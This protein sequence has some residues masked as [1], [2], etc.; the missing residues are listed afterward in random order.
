MEESGLPVTGQNLTNSLNPSDFGK[1][2]F[3]LESHYPGGHYLKFSGFLGTMPIESLKG[4]KYIFT[5]FHGLGEN[6]YNP[7]KVFNSSNEF[8][9]IADVL[10]SEF[11]N[12]P[13]L[14]PL[15]DLAILVMRNEVDAKPFD[16]YL[17][18][19]KK[20][21]DVKTLSY[22][23]TGVGL[24]EDPKRLSPVGFSYGMDDPNVGYLE[25]ETVPGESGGVVVAETEPNQIKAIGTIIADFGRQFAL[26]H[27]FDWVKNLQDKLKNSLLNKLTISSIVTPE[28]KLPLKQFPKLDIP[29]KPV[30]WNSLNYV[31][32]AEFFVENLQDIEWRLFD[33]RGRNLGRLQYG[34]AQDINKARLFHKIVA[35]HNLLEEANLIDIEYPQI[36][37]EDISVLPKDIVENVQEYS[38]KF[39][40]VMSATENSFKPFITT[41]IGREGFCY[42]KSP[43]ER[44]DVMHANV[45]IDNKPITVQEWAQIERFFQALDKYGFLE[46]D[47]NYIFSNT[48]FNRKQ[49]GRL[50]MTITGFGKAGT[51]RYVPNIKELAMGL[52]ETGVKHI[53]LF[54]RIFY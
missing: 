14:G 1:S 46:G 10:F 44:N 27:G 25:G 53:S 39:N 30:A 40:T 6:P 51:Y 4:N 2:V 23:A 17:G 48:A 12:E 47:K 5:V 7:I 19:L 34:T 33:N 45:Q 15:R 16:L 13:S 42:G 28:I 49:N 3:R 52:N 38:V 54:E 29:F 24:K 36:I 21:K 18:N 20:H 8:I 37:S 35:E 32:K 22:P 41:P 11:N 31:T 9:G 50:V 26:F 43:L